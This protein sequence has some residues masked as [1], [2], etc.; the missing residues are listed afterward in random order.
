MVY[1]VSLV[2]QAALTVWVAVDAARRQRRWLA[3]AAFVA[4]TG[5][6]GLVVWLFVRRRGAATVSPLGSRRAAEVAL[7]AI[8]TVALMSIVVV[9]VNTFVYQTARV[10]GQAMS[11]TLADQDRLV[12]NKWLYRIREPRVDDIVMHYYPIDPSRAFI[13]RVVGEEGDQIRI[14]D[15]RVYRNE[16]LLDD[17]FVPPDYRSHDDWGPQVVPEGYYF[18]MGDHRNNS[19]D[20][21]HWGFVPKRYIT[22]SVQFRWWPLRHAR[23]FRLHD[24]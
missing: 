13:K 24:R 17:S 4:L 19:S 20:S 7:S 8:A 6:I 11:P 21:R 5:L 14:V 16:I 2:L 22:G 18:V 9:F 12:I 23:M 15:G 3:W 1:A 10:Q